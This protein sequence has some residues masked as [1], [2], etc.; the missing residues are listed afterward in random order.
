MLIRITFSFFF[1]SI[2]PFLSFFFLG[3]EEGVDRGVF[4]ELGEEALESFCEGWAG[5]REMREKKWNEMKENG[6]NE[7]KWKK[8]KKMKKKKMKKKW[9]KNERKQNEIKKIKQKILLTSQ[10]LNYNEKEWTP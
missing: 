10:Y 1:P 5:G 3:E 4:A 6:E 8:M 7:R 9:K 2:P